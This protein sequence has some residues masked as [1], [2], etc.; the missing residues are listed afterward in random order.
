MPVKT[1]MSKVSESPDKNASPG[2]VSVDLGLK[3]DPRWLSAEQ[4]A[5]SAEFRRSPRL[6]ELLLFIVK[7]S[8]LGED[9]QLTEFEIARQV[10]GRGLNYI[11]TE[12]SIVRSSARQLRWKLK[13]ARESP[14][15]QSPWLLEIPK[16][17]YVAHF[18]LR[19]VENERRRAL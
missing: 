14:D 18:Q 4:L 8:L 15:F 6:R 16:G 12:D 9:E 2:S 10:F 5:A 17:R 3:D 1:T 13:Q 7:H 19:E 11:P